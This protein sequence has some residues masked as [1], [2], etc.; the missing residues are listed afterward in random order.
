MKSAAPSSYLKWKKGQLCKP[1]KRDSVE[2]VWT[3]EKYCLLLCH[4]QW[5]E[6][7]RRY[8]MCIEG[9][10]WKWAQTWGKT[11]LAQV[12]RPV[13]GVEW[14]VTHF[15]CS[16]NHIVHSSLKMKLLYCTHKINTTGLYLTNLLRCIKKNVWTT[17]TLC[18]LCTVKLVIISCTTWESL[19]ST[20]W[21][22]PYLLKRNDY[23]SS[24]EL[25]LPK[26]IIEKKSEI[27]RDI[28]N[29]ISVKILSYSAC[30]RWG[31]G[32]G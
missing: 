2:I 7:V 23:M 10:C 12:L 29:R 17:V 1:W 11:T 13:V 20:L 30:F 15:E 21:E 4:K 26:I 28:K 32:S 8:A 5:V 18:I 25:L 3:P 24:Y 31:W 14:H 9:A 16:F 22:S 27:R 6:K 19:F